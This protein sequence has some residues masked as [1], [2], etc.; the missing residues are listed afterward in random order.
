MSHKNKTKQ[1]EKVADNR[2]VRTNTDKKPPDI[3]S[4][5]HVIP[6]LNRLKQN[7]RFEASLDHMVK[8]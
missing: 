3:H 6:T 1:N 4:D 8:N 5:T 7:C 2:V